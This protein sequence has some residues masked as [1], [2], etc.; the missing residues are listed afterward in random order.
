MYFPGR[1]GEQC[2]SAERPA[3][4]SYAPLL[5]T[6]SVTGHLFRPRACIQLDYLAP[7]HPP[8]DGT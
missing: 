8:L 5:E 3:Y 7:Q 1:T 4:V 2:S 6:N